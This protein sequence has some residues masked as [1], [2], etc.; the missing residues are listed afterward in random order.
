MYCC[1]RVPEAAKLTYATKTKES[2]TSQK[3]SSLDFQQIG[4]SAL[5]KG[6]SAIPPLFND[7]KVTRCFLLLQLI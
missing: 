7:P 2:I 6:K 3:R 5:N 4:N 1:K